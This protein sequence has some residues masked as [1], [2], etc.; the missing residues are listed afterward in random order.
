MNYGLA[1]ATSCIVIYAISR[2]FKKDPYADIPGPYAI[3]ILGVWETYPSFLFAKAHI[4]FTK[5][6]SQY[7]SIFKISQFNQT[8]ILVTDADEIKRILADSDAFVRRSEEQLFEG[9]L[10]DNALFVLGTGDQW[11]RHRKLIQP[12]FGPLHLRHTALVTVQSLARLDQLMDGKLQGKENEVVDIHALMKALTLEVIGKVAFGYSM[13]S[14]EAFF[15]GEKGDW[16][17]F[18]V[19]TTT[20]IPK[21]VVFPKFLWPLFGASTSSS[22]IRKARNHV[23]SLLLVLEN[24]RLEKIKNGEINQENWNMDVLQRLL[25][26]QDQGS[27]TREEIFG[28]LLGFVLAGHETSSNTLSFAIL[29]LARN[30][31]VNEK[32][33]TEVEGVDLANTENI[34]EVIANLKYLDKFLKEV[35][36]RHSVVGSLGRVST[37]DVQ[38]CKYH[39]PKDTK[40]QLYLRAVHMNPEYYKDPEKFDVDRWDTELK[41]NTF[42]PFG[43]GQHN[44]IGQ[45]LAI[46]ET[47]I[48]LIHFIQNYRFQIIPEFVIDN[49]SVITYT[50]KTGLKIRVSKRQ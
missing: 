48:S 44:C 23:E 21:R 50:F 14:I 29:E 4:L 27:L 47:K 13:G 39:F 18:E 40:F 34:L 37:K 42:F 36:R 9:L 22:G 32:L 46:I 28:E 38:V 19:L 11:K 45:K 31:P 7:K 24:Q 5:Y 3:P 20:T 49:I 25:L 6:A 10:L 33:F 8:T 12:A 35:Q 1:A 43:D 2:Y 16:H 17:D 41:P 15:K 30:P 26:S